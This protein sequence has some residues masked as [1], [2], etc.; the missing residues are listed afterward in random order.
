MPSASF[1]DVLRQLY[2]AVICM[3]HDLLYILMHKNAIV[4]HKFTYQCDKG[5]IFPEHIPFRSRLLYLSHK[6]L[7]VQLLRCL[8]ASNISSAAATAAFRDSAFPC[9]G[10][11][12]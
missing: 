4:M 7:T 5:R 8:P 11:I 6:S 3:K 9:M 12:T 10:I 2:Y 1:S